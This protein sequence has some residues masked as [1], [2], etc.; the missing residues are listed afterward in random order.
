MSGVVTDLFCSLSREIFLCVL[1]LACIF[2]IPFVV[3][4]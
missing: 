1:I 2:P 3:V 4:H